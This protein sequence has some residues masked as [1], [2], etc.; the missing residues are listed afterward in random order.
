MWFAFNQTISSLPASLSSTSGITPPETLRIS[1]PALATPTSISTL[2]LSTVRTIAVTLLLRQ[3]VAMLYPQKRAGNFLVEKAA[4]QE[5]SARTWRS[6]RLR[7]AA[8]IR[9]PT[10]AFGLIVSPSRKRSITRGSM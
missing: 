5:I 8:L 4:A 1:S 9:P 3:L 2:R 10:D 6:I 7:A